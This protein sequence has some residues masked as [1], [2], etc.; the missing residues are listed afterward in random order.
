MLGQCSIVKFT[1][2]VLSDKVVFSLTI[3]RPELTR[4]HCFTKGIY[5]TFVFESQ[6]LRSAVS[7]DVVV[8]GF[9][10]D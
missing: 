8:R 4:L 2:G 1:S 9:L 5:Q 10:S 3:L 7:R 6:I